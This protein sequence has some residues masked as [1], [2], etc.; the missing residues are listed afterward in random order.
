MSKQI[1]NTE[2]DLA[3][4][5][6]MPVSRSFGDLISPKYPPTTQIYFENASS[7]K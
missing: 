1:A 5:I 2:Q 4:W 7:S 6:F 3:Q